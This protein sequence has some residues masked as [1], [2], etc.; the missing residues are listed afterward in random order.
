MNRFL[1]TA[2]ETKKGEANRTMVSLGVT[3]SAFFLR[4]SGQR[5]VVVGLAGSEVLQRYHFHV[6]ESRFGTRFFWWVLSP[7]AYKL[8]QICTFVS[9]SGILAT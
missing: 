5:C 9:L 4:D 2:T 1:I 7:I 3:T 6:E 8:S